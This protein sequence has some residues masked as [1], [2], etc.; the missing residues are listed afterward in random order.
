MGR[1]LTMVGPECVGSAKG[2]HASAQRTRTL[3]TASNFNGVIIIIEFVFSITDV[4]V[5]NLAYYTE[6][7]SAVCGEE[8]V[9]RF[10]V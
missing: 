8:R 6:T 3:P 5:F 4:T 10:M 9:R 1:L 7:D 2:G